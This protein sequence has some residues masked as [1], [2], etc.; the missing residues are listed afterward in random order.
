MHE[1]APTGC[2]ESSYIYLYTGMYM[3]TYVRV[4]VLHLYI[5]GLFCDHSG[6]FLGLD[7]LG[8]TF[9]TFWHIFL[10]CL[11]FSLNLSG[12]ILGSFC[13]HWEL[14][15]IILKSVAVFGV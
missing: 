13:D 9:Q 11:S 2:R 1:R 12:I 10:F 14:D 15:W 7:R 4:S 8:I 5:F 3:Y 6:I